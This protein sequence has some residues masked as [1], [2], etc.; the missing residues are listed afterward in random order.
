MK[1]QLENM[2]IENRRVIFNPAKDRREEQHRTTSKLLEKARWQSSKKRTIYEDHMKVAEGS[3]PDSKLTYAQCLMQHRD[4]GKP[5]ET[6]KKEPTPSEAR[7]A[8]RSLNRESNKL[9]DTGGFKYKKVIE[10][11]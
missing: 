6:G 9:H 7:D 5:R 3:K 8:R 4:G 1:K 11:T 10:A 2:W